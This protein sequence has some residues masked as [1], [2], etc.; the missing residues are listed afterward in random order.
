[1][2]GPLYPFHIAL[3]VRDLARARAFYADL[4]G[5]RE[6]RSD[7]RWV[8][9]DL[10]GHQLVCHLV[11]EAEPSYAENPV[12]GDAVPIPHCGVAL[13]L[14][15]WRGLATRLEEAGVEFVIAPRVRFRGEAGEQGTFFLRDPGGNTLE[16]KGFRDLAQLFATERS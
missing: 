12:D 15:R 2:G 10:F 11:A 6:G 1:M 3:P 13:P 5:C 16:F 14:E 8:D 9:F 7:T 4:L